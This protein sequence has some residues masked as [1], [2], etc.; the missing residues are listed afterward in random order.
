MHFYLSHL[1]NYANAELCSKL[2]RL[3]YFDGHLAITGVITFM[4]FRH[5]E[6]SRVVEPPIKSD[7]EWRPLQNVRR[8][9]VVILD[10]FLVRLIL[11]THSN[12]VDRW[13]RSTVTFLT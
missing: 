12:H 2:M 7:F 10:T 11:E 3:T 9:G 8:A 6:E 1:I 13:L 4:E 5:F